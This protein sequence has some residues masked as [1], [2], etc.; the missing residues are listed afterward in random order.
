MMRVTVY[1]ENGA[2]HD[3]TTQAQLDSF[4]ASGWKLKAPK[5]PKGKTQN[6]TEVKK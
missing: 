6:K 5:K 2:V 3:C 4:L 1:H